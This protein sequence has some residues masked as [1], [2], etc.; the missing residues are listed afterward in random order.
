MILQFKKDNKVLTG[1][2]DV[3]ATSNGIQ[4]SGK[5]PNITSFYRIRTAYVEDP[6]FMFII[7]SI[8][9]RVYSKRNE[10]THLMD[11]IM[12][13]VDYMHMI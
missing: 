4:E 3:K 9:H 10:I 7:L 8:K 2:I 6:D 1:N 5:S 12:E 11:G 13:I